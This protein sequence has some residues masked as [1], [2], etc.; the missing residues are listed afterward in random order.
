MKN[1]NQ[2]VSAKAERVTECGTHWSP[3]FTQSTSLQRDALKHSHCL[4]SSLY[5]SLT[6]FSFP[7]RFLDTPLSF[8][9]TNVLQHTLLHRPKTGGLFFFHRTSLAHSQF[10]ASFSQF[11][12]YRWLVS[13]NTFTCFRT[14]F[15]TL[16]SLSSDTPLLLCFVSDSF[17]SPKLSFKK[18]PK[19][20]M[21]GKPYE[22]RL[23]RGYSLKTVDCV[24]RYVFFFLFFFFFF[25]LKDIFWDSN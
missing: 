22:T 1:M 20:P 5:V 6:I 14:E 17:L 2:I 18:S 9:H 16:A 3:L 24:N 13:S 19:S 11:M 21:A 23:I 25:C 12:S 10:Y 15:N 4:H 8:I 7:L